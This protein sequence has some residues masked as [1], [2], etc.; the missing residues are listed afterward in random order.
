MLRQGSLDLKSI[1]RVD[2]EK[3]I[4]EVDVETIQG[5]LENITFSEVTEA[6]MRQYT[7]DAFLKLFR[8]VRFMLRCCLCSTDFLRLA[9]LTLEYLL[10]VQHTLYTHVAALEKELKSINEE[11]SLADRKLLQQGNRILCHVFPLRHNR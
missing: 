2:I 6:D 8:L 11:Q 4:K 5:F 9:Q 7:D 1:A 10:N 3:V